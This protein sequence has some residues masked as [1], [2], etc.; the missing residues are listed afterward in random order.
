MSIKPIDI[1]L[2]IGLS[3]LAIFVVHRFFMIDSCLDMGGAI[4]RFSMACRVGDNLEKRLE[5]SSV[6]LSLYF[7]IGIIVSLGSVFAIKKVRDFNTN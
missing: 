6:L 4:E 1:V 5:I 2:S 7:L 3:L